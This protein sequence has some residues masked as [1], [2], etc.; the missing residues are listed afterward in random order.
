M[1]FDK[2]FNELKVAEM[3][4]PMSAHAAKESDADQSMKATE[5]QQNLMRLND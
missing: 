3:D 1:Q 4:L 2:H 5:V